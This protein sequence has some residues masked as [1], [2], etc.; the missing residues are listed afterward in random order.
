MT[1][2]QQAKQVLAIDPYCHG[3]IAFRPSNGIMRSS[4]S[5]LGGRQ[6]GGAVRMVAEG[7]GV[8]LKCWRPAKQPE[9]DRG[10]EGANYVG[11]A[12]LGGART[13]CTAGQITVDGAPLTMREVDAG[14][15]GGAVA[16]A[17]AAGGQ[18]LT[19]AASDQRITDGCFRVDHAFRCPGQ[20][21]LDVLRVHLPAQ[22]PEY[23]SLAPVLPATHWEEREALDLFGIVPPGHP[24]PRRL[25]LP[26][27]WSAG[28]HPLRK[29]VPW[30]VHPPRQ[31]DPGWV[32]RV[33]HGEGVLL[34]PVG[35]VHAGIIESGHFASA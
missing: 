16:A 12:P 32:P 26:D 33:A 8:A 20:A 17:L 24:E 22:R 6:W 1:T 14:A 4:P 15:L 30:N 25:V 11:H 3:S 21:G 31:A 13:V 5:F 34:M 35:P 10:I 9:M 19:A 7:A 18:Y 29:D 2:I 27:D 28:L 23:P